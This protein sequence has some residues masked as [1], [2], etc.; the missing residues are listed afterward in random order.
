MFILLNHSI[1]SVNVHRI[2]NG[3]Q[4]HHILRAHKQ[5]HKNSPE[6]LAAVLIL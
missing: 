3:F 2:H 1:C 6:E 5:P 4:I